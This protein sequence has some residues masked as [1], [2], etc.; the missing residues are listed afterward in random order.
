MKKNRVADPVGTG[1]FD[2]APVF[3]GGMIRIRAI[4]LFFSVHLFRRIKSN[5]KVDLIILL[6]LSSW[7][8]DSV[9]DSL[10]TEIQVIMLD[11][12][13]IFRIIYLSYRHI[14]VYQTILDVLNVS[15]RS[16]FPKL[17]T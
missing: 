2:P 11:S 15:A 5:E 1:C 6:L 7:G 16:T 14:V 4:L 9:L 13:F 12:I 17:G 10:T 3:H 8:E